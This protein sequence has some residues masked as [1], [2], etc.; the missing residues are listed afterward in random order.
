VADSG[1]AW[2]A[3]KRKLVTAAE[4]GLPRCEVHWFPATDHDIH[5]HRPDELAQLFLRAVQEGIWR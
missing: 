2:T 3:Q 4:A 1:D 5:I